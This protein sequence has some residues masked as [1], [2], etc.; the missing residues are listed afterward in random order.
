MLATGPAAA[1]AWV[2]LGSFGDHL[3]YKLDS[4]SL[5]SVGYPK[6]NP[7]RTVRQGLVVDSAGQ[8]QV[9]F[10]DCA[11]F[12]SVLTLY[13]ADGTLEYDSVATAENRGIDI[14]IPKSPDPIHPDTPPALFMAAACRK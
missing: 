11:G 1:E 12:A 5:H 10:T 9:W 7:R 6:T 8:K 3:R 14:F 4:A 13:R 2:D